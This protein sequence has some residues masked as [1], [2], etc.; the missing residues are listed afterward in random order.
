MAVT[1]LNM[2]EGLRPW[3]N[4]G[5]T[6]LIVDGAGCLEF[7][8]R[9]NWETPANAPAEQRT[10]A[11][12]SSLAPRV[13][14]PPSAG[15]PDARRHDGSARNARAD[16]RPDARTGMQAPQPAGRAQAPSPPPGR[17]CGGVDAS[18]WPENWQK[19]LPAKRS[20]PMLWSYPEL[21]RDLLLKEGPGCKERSACFRGIFER[22]SLFRGT[23]VFWP[24]ALPDESGNMVSNP[25][26]FLSGIKL[27]NPKAVLL[28][29][30]EAVSASRLGL[31]FSHTYDERLS[32]GRLF[33]LFPSTGQLIENRQAFDAACEYLQSRFAEICALHQ[34]KGKL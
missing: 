26:M 7:H 29:G 15:R 9:R 17:P 33:I 16:V 32:G 18:V 1:P 24:M 20:C 8:R 11:R 22:L 14:S 23:S 3:H 2:P 13:P 28:C 21:G 6:H 31:D 30:P 25:E 27:L 19:V 12:S 10:V 5:L 4:L 34:P